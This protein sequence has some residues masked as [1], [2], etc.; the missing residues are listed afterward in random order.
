MVDPSTTIPL[1]ITAISGGIAT[2]IYAF[3]NVKRSECC[4]CECEQRTPKTPPAS[5]NEVEGTIINIQSESA[6]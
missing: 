3:K 1:L 2:I 6:V 4:G 5:L